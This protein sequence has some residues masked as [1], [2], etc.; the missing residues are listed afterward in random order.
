MKHLAQ[1]AKRNVGL[2]GF[3]NSLM[4]KV[5]NKFLILTKSLYPALIVTLLT[6]Q[7]FDLLPT[8]YIML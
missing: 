1:F 5:G 7:M 2:T 4:S 8:L 6:I 3:Y